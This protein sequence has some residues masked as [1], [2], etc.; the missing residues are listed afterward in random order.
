VLFDMDGTLVDSEK[1]WDV[2]LHELATRLGGRL[3]RATRVAMIGATTRRSMVLLHDELGMPTVH[4]DGSP[5]ATVDEAGVWL[6]TRVRE[7]FA[8]G[9]LWRDGAAELVAAV[10][11]AGL[12]TGLVTATR[13]ELVEV[14][15]STLGREN[16]DVLVCG[17]DVT[18]P[19]P[20]PE[21]YRLAAALLGVDPADCVAIEDS[22]TGS[23]S[24]EAA[25]CAVLVVPSE[26]PV[27]A[28]PRRVQR[29]SLV[30]VTVEDILAI[31]SILARA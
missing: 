16:F 20:D 28:G 2:A 19:K 6:E 8:A 26:A 7:L 22:A 1:L 23:A 30:G 27:P 5:A 14:A 21:P 24:A 3:S 13:R 9:L 15:L 10:R 4:P 17:N 11:A 29:D 31:P 18:C 12:R 25:G